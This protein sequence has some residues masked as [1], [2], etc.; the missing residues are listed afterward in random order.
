MKKFLYALLTVLMALPAVAYASE[1]TANPVIRT[2]ENQDALTIIV[3]GNGTLNVQVL[4][5]NDYDWNINTI[6]DEA[7]VEGHYEY[8]IPRSY[9]DGFNGEVIATA[10]EAG[11]TI[12]ET[13]HKQF[14]MR[15]YYV[16]PQPDI[17]FTEDDGGVIIDVT[18]GVALLQ[19]SITVNGE[20][21]IYDEEATT[22]LSFYIERGYEELYIEVS[23]INQG[24]T[25]GDIWQ[26]RTS[27]YVL[28]PF[29]PVEP[30]VALAPSF[31]QCGYDE[32]FTV[33]AHSDEDGAVVHLFL[34]D[35]EVENPY[36][37]IRTDEDQNFMFKAYAEVP[38]MQRSEW[39][40]FAITVPAL[41]PAEPIEEKTTA[42]LAGYEIIQ[43]I[44]GRYYALVTI[45]QSE[46]SRIYYM[47]L[48][49]DGTGY[50]NI[51]L[52]GDTDQDVQELYFNEPG[53]YRV[54]AWATAD[55]KLTSDWVAV[56]FVLTESPTPSNLYDFEEDGIFYE[57]TSEG[58]VSVC[59]ETT[60]YN[61]YSGNVSIPTTVT[62]DG[63]TYMVT[64]IADNAFRDCAGLTD[65]SIGAYVTTI[66]DNAFLRCT[67]LTSVTLGDY[68]TRLGKWAFA[69]CTALAEVKMGSGMRHIDERAFLDCNA[70]TSVTCKA[71]TPPYL[72]HKGCFDCYTRAT[73][74][75][76]PAVLDSYRSTNIF[77]SQF[78]TI[79]GED[80]VAPAAGDIN[81]DGKMSITDV[82]SL[83]NM[84]LGGE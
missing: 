22:S 44:D 13:V 9:D 57:I 27:F 16:L 29:A 36:T 74:H 32:Y 34:N 76:Y 39:A 77:W 78:A 67:S 55:G 3:E 11:M 58:K 41:E 82:T 42:P 7:Q 37:I 21:V 73:L 20:P 31:L 6:V 79:V 60:E 10:Q 64:A 33:S 40:D 53:I 49:I 50:E 2:E 24:T 19:V 84:L 61:T 54:L 1:Q 15:H 46:P 4:R 45:T 81:G 5:D 48:S 51:I 28:P 38:G 26:E 65:V 59:S 62:H 69:Y 70:L 80:N 35:D 30:Q 18:G 72:F 63:V 71:A 17:T 68:V 75:V 52:E 25:H 66:G 8:T 12:S 23:A 43:D 47:A 56:E 14:L 83:I